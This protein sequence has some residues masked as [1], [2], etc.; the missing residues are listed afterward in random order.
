MDVC[1]VDGF[2]VKTK[3]ATSASVEVSPDLVVSGDFSRDKLKVFGKGE[4]TL[5]FTITK[6]TLKLTL[7]A[8]PGDHAKP[9][10]YALTLGCRVTG[11]LK[12]VNNGER[13]MHD[14]IKA[15]IDVDPEKI[16]LSLGADHEA[17]HGGGS[18]AC[19][20]VA[21]GGPDI[22]YAD[23]Q[24]KTMEEVA[25][26]L[27]EQWSSRVL[28]M[29]Q[30]WVVLSV[31]VQYVTATR[32]RHHPIPRRPK[33]AELPNA[34]DPAYCTRYHGTACMPCTSVDQWMRSVP[35]TAYHV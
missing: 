27:D 35:G 22:K 16:G 15:G 30:D 24:N 25:A 7:A 10:I 19:E 12:I 17:E 13:K 33:P 8:H 31:A 3:T 9:F 4:G 6:P 11:T 5:A 28:G 23:M 1:A 34:H 20:Y 2:T 26:Y 18:H 21:D 14:T 32:F 29:P